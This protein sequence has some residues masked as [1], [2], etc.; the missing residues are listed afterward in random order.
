MTNERIKVL[1]KVL[2]DVEQ[3]PV[4]ACEEHGQAVFIWDII[5]YINEWVRLEEQGFNI[6]DEDK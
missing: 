1:K 6:L 5:N 3:M 2:K 4:V